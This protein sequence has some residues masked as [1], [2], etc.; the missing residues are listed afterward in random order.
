M[1][2]SSTTSG[3]SSDSS[4]LDTELLDSPDSGET[5]SDGKVMRAF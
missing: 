3:T 1:P 4:S 2:G 5:D